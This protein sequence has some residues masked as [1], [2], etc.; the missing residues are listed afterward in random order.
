MALEWR[1]NLSHDSSYFIHFRSYDEMGTELGNPLFFNNTYSIPKRLKVVKLDFQFCEIYLV[2]V[3]LSQLL[4]VR[5]SCSG[6]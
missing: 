5:E 6:H 3:G 1:F 2:V 4:L